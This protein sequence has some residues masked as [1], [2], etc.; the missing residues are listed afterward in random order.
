MNR[1]ASIIVLAIL[2]I[3]TA[4]FT[5]LGLKGMPLG[6]YDFLPFSK[7]IS[8]GLDLKGGVFAVYAATDESQ[9]DLTNKINLAMSIMRNRL[10][11]KGYTEAT[12]SIQKGLNG[13]PRIRVEVPDVSDPNAVYDLIGTPAHLQFKDPDGKVVMEGLHVKTAKA[14]MQSGQWVV[15]FTLDPTGASQ[16]AEATSRLVNQPLYIYLDN[17]E[18]EHPN[19]NQPITGGS[20]YIEGSFTQGSAEQL[21][22]QLQSGALPLSLMRL[23]AQSISASLGVD[24]LR[25]SIEAGAIGL[26]AVIIFMIAFYRLPGFLSCISLIVHTLL[27]LYALALFGIQL[28]LPG[29]AG[30]ILGIGMSVDANVIIFARIRDE[31]VTGKTL[32]SSVDAGFRKAFITIFDSNMT[33]IIAGCVLWA[34]G[35]GP[36]K[37]FAYTMLLGVILSMFTAITLT[38]FLMNVMIKLNITAHWLYSHRWQK[39]EVAK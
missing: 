29:V 13:K 2:I 26:I 39:E 23:E 7:S 36:I 3:V 1:R 33:N 8:Q 14:A 6:R 34:L 5:Y 35:T 12:L 25:T 16:F 31:L 30:I 17:Q 15:D 27:L 18:I 10:D 22:T 24:A 28:T 9:A 20:G 37:G 38:R 21:A 4:G 32:R 19:V 11:S